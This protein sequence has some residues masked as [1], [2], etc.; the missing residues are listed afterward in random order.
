MR[1]EEFMQVLVHAVCRQTEMG[2]GRVARAFAFLVTYK[3]QRQMGPKYIGSS[4]RALAGWQL[5]MRSRARVS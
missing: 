5:S 4:P 3:W 2:T 1:S